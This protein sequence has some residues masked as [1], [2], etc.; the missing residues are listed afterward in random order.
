VEVLLFHDNISLSLSKGRGMTRKRKPQLL[1]LCRVCTRRWVGVGVIIFNAPGRSL[2][3]NCSFCVRCRPLIILARF[4]LGRLADWFFSNLIALNHA[5][6]KH[7]YHTQPVLLK[8][9]AY[10]VDP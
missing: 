2:L 9:H 6:D 3:A 8:P 7:E 4:F 5:C 10:A 1:L